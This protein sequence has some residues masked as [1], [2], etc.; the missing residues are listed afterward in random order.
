MTIKM[1][2]KA[3]KRD[4]QIN[5]SIRPTRWHMFVALSVPFHGHY[6]S[7]RERLWDRER[8]RQTQS[9]RLRK[10]KCPGHNNIECLLSF[11]LTI[12]K[13]CHCSWTSFDFC[14]CFFAFRHRCR[15]YWQGEEERGGEDFDEI[16][17]ASLELTWN[18]CLLLEICFP[19]LCN[20][21]FLVS[22]AHFLS[23]F[24]R[25]EDNKETVSYCLKQQAW[26]QSSRQKVRA[27]RVSSKK[28]WEWERETTWE[29]PEMTQ[30]GQERQVCYKSRWHLPF[31]TL[32]SI[33]P[34][35]VWSWHTFTS[36]MWAHTHST[37]TNFVPIYRQTPSVS[38][39]NITRL[40]CHHKCRS[41]SPWVC[42]D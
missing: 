11:T 42:R 37:H 7:H 14:R 31:G 9:D 2:E 36:N 34:T 3:R 26:W 41:S 21:T 30:S 23:L 25:R 19:S 15:C 29:D 33:R 4:K 1:K 16:R 17:A 5:L 40:V 38:L 18:W 28:E 39:P 10:R 8:E 20:F 27:S 24:S 13:H 22:L 32:R 35:F 12:T 6:S